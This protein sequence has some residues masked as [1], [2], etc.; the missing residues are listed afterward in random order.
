[1]TRISDAGTNAQ[2]CLDL[3]GWLTAAT[4][5]VY[6]GRSVAGDCLEFVSRVGSHRFCH[7]SGHSKHA[8]AVRR[9]QNPFR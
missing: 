8:K 3:F 9:K 5:Y 6:I 7:R 2:W 1:M 4:A